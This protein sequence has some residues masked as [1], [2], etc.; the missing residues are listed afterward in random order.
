MGNFFKDFLFIHFR[1]IIDMILVVHTN[2]LCLIFYNIINICF[3]CIYLYYIHIKSIFAFHIPFIY[4]S[5]WLTKLSFIYLIIIHSFIVWFVSSFGFMFIY[6]IFISSFPYFF[7]FLNKWRLC[8][9]NEKSIRRKWNHSRNNS[10]VSK[11]CFF[12]NL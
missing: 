7:S 1:F 3:I 9:T 6:S 2:C 11:V 4:I 10:N 5:G 12:T 8:K